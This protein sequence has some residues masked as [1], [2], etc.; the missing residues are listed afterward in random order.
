MINMS[1]WR[2]TVVPGALVKWV[3]GWPGPDIDEA[4]IIEKLPDGTYKARSRVYGSGEW[5]EVVVRIPDAD[6][7]LWI[8]DIIGMSKGMY[9][10]SPKS[11]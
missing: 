9:P 3:V 1:D 6:R 10:D 11:S 7:G 8:G 5:F 4:Q 2:E